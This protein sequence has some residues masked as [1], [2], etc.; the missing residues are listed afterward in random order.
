MRKIYWDVWGRDAGQIVTLYRPQVAGAAEGFE[1][2]AEGLRLSRDAS[3][4]RWCLTFR[5]R[6]IATGYEAMPDVARAIAIKRIS[7]GASRASDIPSRITVSR[8]P[9]GPRRY[10]AECGGCSGEG[11]SARIAIRRLMEDIKH[12][13]EIR[14]EEIRLGRT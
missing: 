9:G 13:R 4:C 7:L 2:E 1:G 6:E 3:D 12:D 11:S 14:R 5:D 8:L 10:L